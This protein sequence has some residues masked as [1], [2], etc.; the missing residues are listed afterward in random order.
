MK[1]KVLVVDA[2]ELEEFLRSNRS[3]ST[4]DM[5]S[6]IG[7]SG[8][9][10]ERDDV[11]EDESVRQVI[12]Y[13]TIISGDK[14]AVFQRNKGGEERLKGKVTVGIGGH[15]NPCDNIFPDGVDEGGF[16]RGRGVVTRC[17]YREMAEE[18][19]ADDVFDNG[20]DLAFTGWILMHE[21]P[22]DRVHAGVHFLYELDNDV[23]L[24]AN[25]DELVFLGW[26]SIGDAMKL[27]DQEKWTVEVLER[28]FGAMDSGFIE[29]GE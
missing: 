10:L 24:R 13:V 18:V 17:A 20:K 23:F 7:R 15:I 19:C 6:F 22:V 26:R 11:E 1:E 12:P 27:D 5:Y 28:L 16:A 2:K 14:V 21:N 29:G 4:R 9:F 3:W 25:S 8:V